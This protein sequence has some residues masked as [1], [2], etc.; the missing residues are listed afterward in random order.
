M[1]DLRITDPA[2]T[3]FGLEY[4][5]VS[6][7]KLSEDKRFFNYIVLTAEERMKMPKRSHFTMGN[8]VHN[9]VQ[10]ILCKKETLKDVIF[11][12]DKS[13]FKSLKAEKPIDEKDK[14]KRYYMAKNFKLTLKQFQT[15]IESLPKQNW[16]F[17]TEYATW[18]DGIG[19]YFKMFIDL[20]GE[21]YIVDLKNIFGS[22]IKTKKGYSYTKR[23]VPNLP[24]HSDCMQMAA[25]SFATGGKKPVLIYANHF[26]HKVFTE[27]NC[28]DLKP[29]NLKHFLDELVMYQQIW[30]QKLK[31]ANGNPYALARLIKPDFSDIRKKQD[32]FWNDI[33]EE[34]INRFLNY[35]KNDKR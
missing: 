26:E 32:F 35:Y 16:N 11:N 21:N 8:I 2:Y 6:Q 3:A 22:V 14:A 20:E 27:N 24:F 12:K 5:S 9:A 33:P 30:E 18:I 7:N 34:Y 23:A 25:Y 13:L 17:E 19:T 15:A 1:N 31:M 29:E 4:A 10:K 28:D